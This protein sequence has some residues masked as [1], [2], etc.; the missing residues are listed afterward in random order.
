MSKEIII[1]IQGEKAE[2]SI[3]INLDNYNEKLVDMLYMKNIKDILIKTI[4]EEMK[5]E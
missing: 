3:K 2:G 4:N 1:T 5:E